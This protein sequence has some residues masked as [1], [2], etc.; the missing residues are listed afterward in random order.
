LIVAKLITDLIMIV[1]LLFASW[2]AAGRPLNDASSME[3][4]RVQL[5]IY[6]CIGDATGAYCPGE[7]STASGQPVGP[8]ILA[9]GD[10]FAIGDSIYLDGKWLGTCL[11]RGRGPPAWIDVWVYDAAGGERWLAE[12]GTSVIVERRR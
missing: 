11:D 5:T 8:G 7:Q 2:G 4:V 1:S 6:A 9:C 12:T 10:L 3:L